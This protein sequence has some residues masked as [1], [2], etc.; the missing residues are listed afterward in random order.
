MYKVDTSQAKIVVNGILKNITK[1]Y[2]FPSQKRQ[3]ERRTAAEDVP[4]A[5]VAT[6]RPVAEHHAIVGPEQR[7][8]GDQAVTP[9]RAGPGEL[10]PGDVAGG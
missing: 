5:R 9:V 1:N 4:F 8:R 2:V 10:L 6:V 7:R 3:S